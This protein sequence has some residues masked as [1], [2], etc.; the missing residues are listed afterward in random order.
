MRGRDR[1]EEGTSVREERKEARERKL[2][3]KEGQG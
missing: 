1:E 3:I 2:K